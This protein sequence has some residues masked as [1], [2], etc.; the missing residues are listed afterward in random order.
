MAKI[1]EKRK[2]KS[3]KKE[4]VIQNI[5]EEEILNVGEEFSVD[6]SDS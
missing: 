1:R 2:K 4:N 3:H 5:P 6:S